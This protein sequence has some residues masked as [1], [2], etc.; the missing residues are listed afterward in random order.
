MFGYLAV[1]FPGVANRSLGLD[2]CGTGV[3][4][5]GQDLAAAGVMEEDA[6]APVAVGQSAHV[7]E[8]GS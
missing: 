6:T 3:R 5:C 7:R 4:F 1:C 2:R 8:A